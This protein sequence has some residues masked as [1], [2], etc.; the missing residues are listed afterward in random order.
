MFE[1]HPTPIRQQGQRFA[2]TLVELLVVIAIIGILVALL[3]P[4]VNAAREAARRIQCVNNLKQIVL[5]SLNY[6]STYRHLPAGPWDGDPN[7]TTTSGIPSRS[8]RTASVCCRAANSDGWS[9]LF[10]IL[11]FLEQSNVFD[12]AADD[13]PFW[14]TQPN[15]S[16]ED[17]VAQQRI[18]LFY[19]PARRAPEGYGSPS[20]DVLTMPGV[21]GFITVPLTA[22]SVSFLRPR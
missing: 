19:C 1:I 18:S 9:P 21:L 12:M 22:T 4:A 20:L 2:F 10:R 5:A 3:L 7:A 17:D 14:P 6:K 16:N 15:N 11:P 13:G 8:G